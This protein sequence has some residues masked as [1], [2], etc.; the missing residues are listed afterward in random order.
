M[1]KNYQLNKKKSDFR[2]ERTLMQRIFTN[3][4]APQTKKKI[5]NDASVTNGNKFKSCLNLHKEMSDLVSL[6]KM[7]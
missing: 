6:G 5:I 4:V 7:V 2:L 3:L 1:H